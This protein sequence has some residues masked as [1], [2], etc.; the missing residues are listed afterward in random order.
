MRCGGQSSRYGYVGLLKKPVNCPGDPPLTR[1]LPGGLI[2]L[3]ACCVAR[4]SGVTLYAGMVLVSAR[5][6]ACWCCDEWIIGHTSPRVNHCFTQLHVVACAQ[7]PAATMGAC[8]P[9]H[10]CARRK[11][12]AWAGLGGGWPI[13][14]NRGWGRGQTR[15][16]VLCISPPSTKL[17][18]FSFSARIIQQ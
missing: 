2:A 13:C 3:S 12:R 9:A 17:R 8:T 5:C 6:V 7:Q 18:Y 1:T 15:A 10:P 14:W 11:I 16:Q 4:Q